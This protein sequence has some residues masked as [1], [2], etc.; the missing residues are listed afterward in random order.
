MNR[1]IQS[2][3]SPSNDWWKTNRSLL[4][5]VDHLE[6]R[7]AEA[8]EEN[9]NLQQRCATAKM[10]HES[11]RRRLQSE[12]SNLR[13]QANEMLKRLQQ[14]M[15]AGKREVAQL[16]AK[17]RLVRD[18]QERKIQ[19]LQLE[20]KNERSLSELRLR[21]VESKIANCICG[22]VRIDFDGQSA[23]NRSSSPG[24]ESREGR[25]RWAIRNAK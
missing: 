21:Q 20:L 7:L 10:E 8:L 25:E 1:V 16:T 3:T 15:G 4:E 14:K 23:R 18:E 12:L 2:Q 5:I 11:E 9:Q 22:D 6:R 19:A 17:E 24:R 13:L